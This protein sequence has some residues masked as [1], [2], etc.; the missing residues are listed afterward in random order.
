MPAARP[1]QS[2]LRAAPRRSG[3]GSSGKV[4][5]RK[6]ERPLAERVN[7]G[8][9]TGRDLGDILKDADWFT[10]LKGAARLKTG[11]VPKASLVVPQAQA[12]QVL[13]GIVRFVADVPADSSSIV[14]WQEAGSELWV[15]LAKTTITCAEGVVGIGVTVGCDELD[16]S[17]TLV[18]PFSVGTAE[19]PSG[20]IMSTLDRLDGPE[21]VVARWSA[22]ITAY[23]WE[24]LLELA[25]R[26]CAGLGRDSRRLALIPGSI[27]AA[28]GSLLIQ[29]MSRHDLSGMRR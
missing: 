18:V 14:V 17:A 2:A 10:P 12:Q 8:L 13:R 1:R 3:G 21:V 4:A 9:A 16:G 25:T 22:A 26:L 19:R 24:A 7:V 15:D 6:A 29:P 23:A 11:S 5:G 27:G 28:R 20:L